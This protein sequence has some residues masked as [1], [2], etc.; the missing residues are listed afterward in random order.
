MV[1]EQ[2]VENWRFM[3][4]CSSANTCADGLSE[5]V[6]ATSLTIDHSHL[7]CT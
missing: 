5:L 4:F 6:I 3:E 2:V 1:I 7:E